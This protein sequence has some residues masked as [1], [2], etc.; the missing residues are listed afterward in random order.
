MLAIKGQHDIFISRGDNVKIAVN[1]IEKDSMGV[2]DFAMAN[3][4]YLV[5]RLWDEHMQ[6]EIKQIR[7]EDGTTIIAIAP[8]FTEGLKGRYAYSVDLVFL[9]GTKDTVI[10]KSPSAIAKFVVLEA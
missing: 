3:T 8:S 7:S 6:R 10:G 1:L 9:D 4:D 5:F 2:S